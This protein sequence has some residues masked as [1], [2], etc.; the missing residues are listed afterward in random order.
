MVRSLLIS[1]SVLPLVQGCVPD[2]DNIEGEIYEVC[3]L[4]Q[5]ARVSRTT[6][7]AARGVITIDQVDLRKVEV[8]DPIV[9]LDM[10]NVRLADGANDFDFVDN[11]HIGVGNQRVVGLDK[12]A[13]DALGA[14]GESSVNL[15]EHATEQ[16][17]SLS[18]NLEG[19]I[20]AAALTVDV[21]VCFAVSGVKVSKD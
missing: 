10:V 1:L 11:A 20:P 9:E 7:G 21:D 17:L 14:D 13:R 16:D 19:D 5:S 6:A 3:Y 4:D 2:T 8:I 15:F 12:I 18:V